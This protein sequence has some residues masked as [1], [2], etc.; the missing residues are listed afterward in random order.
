MPK[1]TKPHR[2]SAGRASAARAKPRRAAPQDVAY[3]RTLA[4][5]IRDARA[6]RG[7]TRNAL[8]SG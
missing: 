1:S 3:L 4:D 7:M 2:A 5:K 6:Q 8:A